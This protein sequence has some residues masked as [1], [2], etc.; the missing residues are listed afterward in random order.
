[1]YNLLTAN[2]HSISQTSLLQ[3]LE[4][5]NTFSLIFAANRENVMHILWNFEVIWQNSLFDM[6][7]W[8]SALM[9]GTFR[10][11]LELVYIYS[12]RTPSQRIDEEDCKWVSGYQIV[13]SIN[14]Y[15]FFAILTYI[16]IYVY[17]NIDKA[18]KIAWC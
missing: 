15:A 10:Y 12:R 6:A 14:S 2:N 1:M 16:Y 9:R 5:N 17:N 13:R 3:R 18:E 7:T 11:L 4:C 8:I